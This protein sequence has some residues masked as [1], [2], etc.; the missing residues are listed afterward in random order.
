VRYAIDNNPPWAALTI[1]AFYRKVDRD[2]WVEERAGRQ[3]I[4]RGEAVRLLSE[5]YQQNPNVFPVGQNV[6][7]G[8]HRP[9][10]DQDRKD[11]CDEQRYESRESY[12]P[13]PPGA[14]RESIR[15]T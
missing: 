2:R 11:V 3:K 7:L 8:S 4:Y 13:L 6:Y 9:S 10:R 1:V 14:A 15:L 5:L 12:R